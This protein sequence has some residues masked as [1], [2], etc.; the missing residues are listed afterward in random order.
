MRI[1]L[2]SDL[3]FEVMR[4]LWVPPVLNI[5]VVILAGNTPYRFQ[6]PSR[7][8][9]QLPLLRPLRSLTL[10]FRHR[11]VEHHDGHP[12]TLCVVRPSHE[13]FLEQSIFLR[14][15]VNLAL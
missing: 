7:P 11:R 14:Q 15:S 6:D 4:T 12:F 5:D 1:D 2:Y 8:R 9:G 3:H 10:R 13:L